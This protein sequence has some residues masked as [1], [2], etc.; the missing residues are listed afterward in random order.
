MTMTNTHDKIHICRLDTTSEPVK[1]VFT[2]SE[3]A[4]EETLYTF[5]SDEKSYRADSFVGMTVEAAR[6]R[7]LNDDQTYLQSPQRLMGF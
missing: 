3:G 2:R 1:I 5:F 7:V 6:N 4:E